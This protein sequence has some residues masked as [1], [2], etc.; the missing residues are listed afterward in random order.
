MRHLYRIS[1][2]YYS[3]H[4]T[5]LTKI[6]LFRQFCIILLKS[7]RSAVLIYIWNKYYERVFYHSVFDKLSKRISIY[8]FRFYKWI[9]FYKVLSLSVSISSR[10]R[11][12][13]V[14]HLGNLMTLTS[15][16]E[17]PYLILFYSICLLRSSLVG[18]LLVLMM[19][20]FLRVTPVFFMLS[21]NTFSRLR[22]SPMKSP[23]DCWPSRRWVCM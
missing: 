8:F 14:L 17:S 4:N 2:N 10:V 1:N 18:L 6:H 12:P 23:R 20:L 5:K 16:L 22:C 13:S 15:S 21:W 9:I 19:K 3:T 11:N 7:W